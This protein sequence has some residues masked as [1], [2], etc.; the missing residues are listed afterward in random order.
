MCRLRLARASALVLERRGTLPQDR[1]KTKWEIYQS[2]RR[3]VSFLEYFASKT[4]EVTKVYTWK[5]LRE[6][7]QKQLEEKQN[8]CDPL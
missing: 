2:D 6:T 1:T 4:V 3:S 8:F 5:F 7:K